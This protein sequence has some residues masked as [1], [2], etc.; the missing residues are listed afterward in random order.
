MFIELEGMKIKMTRL[1]GVKDFSPL[2]WW[3]AKELPDSY[4]ELD[5]VVYYLFDEQGN[6]HGSFG[7]VSQMRYYVETGVIFQLHSTTN[8]KRWNAWLDFE[9]M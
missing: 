9:R 8:R 7:K 3:Y 5:G 6:Y 1:N 4:G 2:K